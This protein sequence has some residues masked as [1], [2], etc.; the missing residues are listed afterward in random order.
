MILQLCHFKQYEKGSA[1]INQKE[2]ALLAIQNQHHALI[3]VCTYHFN[4][5]FN[6]WMCH[7]LSFQAW[8][9]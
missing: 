2:K 5:I 4:S 9:T 1:G 8:T 7:C 3:G 6:H